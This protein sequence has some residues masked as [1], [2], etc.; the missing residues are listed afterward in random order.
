MPAPTRKMIHAEE[1]IKATLPTLPFYVQEY[2]VARRRS[3]LSSLTLSGYL[4]D[5]NKFFTWLRIEG[6]SEA[7]S[8]AHIPF[9]VL[10]S[11][12]K[13]DI[14][15]FFDMLRDEKIQ[16]QEGVH[17]KRSLQ[18]L[19]R[20]MQSLK[21]LFNYLT[22]ETEDENG[23]SYFYRNV[24]AK[25][26][27]PRKQESAG[28]R[29]KR[30]NAQTLN[31]TEMDGLVNFMKHDYA[32]SLSPRALSRFQRD[33]L[34]DI[35]IISLFNGSGMRAGEV[36]GLLVSDVDKTHADITALRKG[37]GLD[38]VSILPSAMDDVIA[39][40]DVREE[41]YKPEPKNKYLFL[42]RYKG[43][44][45]PISQESIEKIVKKYTKAYLDGKELSPH[46]LRHSFAKR[47]LDEGGSLVALRD[48]LGHNDIETTT[49]Y[50]NH[51]QDEHREI[52]NKMD[53]SKK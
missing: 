19:N 53:R 23:E 26:R 37:N 39:Y 11:L 32:A 44:A 8:N 22:T 35:A 46:K 47:Y 7:E 13:N 14:E 33:Q 51:S 1:H 2:V 12:T 4:Y 6:F 36:A 48:Q 16:K 45:N 31:A 21:S 20:Y 30:I 42:T 28:Y 10:E 18:S 5:F 52:L 24:M 49:L 9:T 41:I 17:V 3:G 34:R 38:T 27:T 15:M 50:T 25:V 40:M 29:A 43:V